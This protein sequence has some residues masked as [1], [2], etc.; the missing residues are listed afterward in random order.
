MINK[1]TLPGFMGEGR[2][3]SV[4]NQILIEIICLCWVINPFFLSTARAA[5]LPA[6]FAETRLASGLDPTGMEFAPDGRL[7]V[8]EKPGRIRIIKNG[9]LLAT[10]FMTLSVNNSNE[11]G[12]LGIAF[13]PNFSSN[14]YVYL[15]YTTASSPIHNR[16]SRFTANGDVVQPGSE[17]VIFELNELKAGNHNG[18]TIFFSGGKL[19]IMTGENAVPNNSQTTDNLLGKVLRINPD[20]SI[21]ADNPFYN[22]AKGNNRAIWAIGLRN[23][24]R[25]VVQPGTGRIF[26]ND[27][28]GGQAE[29]INEGF[30]G[31]NYGWPG[32]EGA[33]RNQTPP[34][35]Y[36]EPLYTYNRSVGCAIT[37]GTFYNPATVQFPSSYVGRYF[38]T[39]YCNGQ[40]NMVDV[41]KGNA[42][43]TFATG[44]NRAVDVKVGPDGSLYYIA[45]G[46][47]GNGSYED[48]TSSNNGEVWRVRYTGSNVPTISAQPASRTASLGEA[49]TFTVGASGTGLSYQWQRNGANIAGATTA[50]YTLSSVAQSDNGATFR[51]IVSNAS[52]NATSVNATLTVN[53]NRPP[54]ARI[55]TPTDGSL[56]RGG[57]TISFS[58]TGTDPDDGNLPASAFSWSVTFHHAQHTHPGPTPT[59]AGDG[60]SGTFTIPTEGETAADVWFRLFL[61]VT[62][63]KGSKSTV[64]VDVD[65]KLV[66]LTVDTKPSNLQVLVDGQ[67]QTAPY[68]RA[69][70]AGTML[71]LATASQTQTKDGKIYTFTGWKPDMSGRI[72]VPDGNTTYTANFKEDKDDGSSGVVAGATY[73]ITAKHSGK[74]LSISYASLVDG[75]VLKQANAT[76]E[77]HQKWKLTAVGNGYYLIKNV[78]S[79]KVLDVLDSSLVDGAAITQWPFFDGDNQKFK[80]VDA[81]GGYYQ[82]VA[83]HSNKGLSL[84]DELKAH[85]AAVVQWSING[86]DHQKFRFTKLSDPSAREAVASSAASDD[87]RSLTV[88]PNPADQ[89]VQLGGVKDAVVQIVDLLGTVQSTLSSLTDRLT[90]DVSKLPVGLYIIQARKN[91]QLSSRKLVVSR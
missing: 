10:P 65:P 51:V 52:G 23:P 59:V 34:S 60:R 4:F 57:Q 58:G 62:D 87:D 19:F 16:I 83:K 28:G 55:L 42:V 88:Y 35:N 38:F 56:Y 11:R 2:T 26:I 61:T 5:S 64:S 43:S 24:F 33:R 20:G 13:D 29:E 50:S 41:G 18:G 8:L 39:D 1:C 74:V 54:T 73:M 36:Q 91:N 37:G 86:K 44:I 40:I 22:T 25:A 48:N 67:P 14:R 80:L 69:F 75:A 21:P 17:K 27:V 82:I 71:S 32:I 15:Y 47:I 63:S 12:L 78:L 53:A 9:T 70:V 84:Q 89:T 85:G 7:F 45:R 3:V 90:V 31:K 30:A 49:V 68:S 66:T 72:T 77:D 81:G 46:G 6:N 79:G 76:G